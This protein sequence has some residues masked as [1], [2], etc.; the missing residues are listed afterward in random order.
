MSVGCIASKPQTTRLLV[1]PPTR[2]TTYAN[3]Q[4]HRSS[5]CT[6]NTPSGPHPHGTRLNEGSIYG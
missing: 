6:A 2:R 3:A 4:G 1:H 5:T